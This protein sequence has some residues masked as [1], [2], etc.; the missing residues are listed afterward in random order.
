MNDSWLSGIA[1][2]RFMGRWSTL[3]AQKFLSWLAISPTRNW[4]DVG[5]GTGSLTKI[6]LDSYQP[7]EIIAIDS[8]GDFIAHAQHSI[9]NP[10]VY[11][12]VGLAQSLEL[13]ANSMDA[14]VSGLV[15]NFIPQPKIA[16]SEMA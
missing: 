13:D 3:V 14:V 4:L 15:L 8:S 10:S 7:K 6:I 12:R 2:E 9:R 11:F 5:C 1:Y 16:I